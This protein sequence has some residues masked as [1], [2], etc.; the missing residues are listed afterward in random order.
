[1]V[2]KVDL[3]MHQLPNLILLHTFDM[4]RDY[5]NVLCEFLNSL[6]KEPVLI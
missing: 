1:M 4:L 6:S 3:E 2:I 5:I